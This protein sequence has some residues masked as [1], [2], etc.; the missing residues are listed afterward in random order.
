MQEQ[1][2][3]LKSIGQT[4][5]N[6]GKL[7]ESK[8]NNTSID[9]TTLI[10]EEKEVE[11]DDDIYMTD[12]EKHNARR[13]EMRNKKEEANKKKVSGKKLSMFREYGNQLAKDLNA[14]EFS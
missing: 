10:E 4:L 11:E 6:L 8:F 12:R 7:I 5:V 2:Q 9:K 13:E 3:T 14:E 1:S